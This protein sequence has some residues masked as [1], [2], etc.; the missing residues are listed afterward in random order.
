MQIVKSVLTGAVVLF[1]P[2]AAAFPADGPGDPAG[3]PEAVS[4]IYVA[5]F[6][7][8]AA[9]GVAMNDAGDVVGTSYP[10]PGCGP[11][12]LPPLQTVVWKRGRRIL[13]LAPP[14]LT[15]VSVR[16]ISSRGWVAGFAGFPPTVATHAV[17]WKWN[18]SSYIGTDLGVLPGTTTSEATGID[19]LGR[20]VGWSTTLSFPPNGSPFM[21]SEAAGMVDLSAQGFPGD[22]PLAI[23][24]GGAVATPGYW[25]QLDDP[26]SA[27]PMPSAP[28]GFFGPGAYPT[29][30]ND[31]GDQ[32]RFLLSTGG[33]SPAYLFR[34]HQ[35]GTWQ[36]ISF[37]P[38]FGSS[39]F[40]VGSIN[41][42]QD[43]TA[44]VLGNA[45]IAG[46]PDGL[47]QPLAP[48]LSPAYNSLGIASG[49]PMNASGQILAQVFIG[50]SRRLMRLT[51]GSFCT[52]NCI[53][54]NDL[55][56]IGE[57]VQDPA[58]PGH[59]SQGNH[60]F[61]RVRTTLTV[62]DEGGEPLPGVVVRG[63]FL[64][65]YWTD[66]PVSATT[67]PQGQVTFKMRG[68]CGVGAVAFLVDSATRG[69]Q[70]LDKTTGILSSWVIPQ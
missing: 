47:A 29:A 61:N 42:A 8:T 43:I 10:D 28:Q 58:D 36:Q 62:T 31:S 34:F 6:V 50:R 15:G 5:E 67:D 17:V 2:A 16:G 37:T 49:G 45:Q 63:R 56:M 44:T 38:N 33:Q 13:L 4:A 3:T 54:A 55:Q 51:P 19:S 14:G 25:Y 52:A 24:P 12:C 41:A 9:F 22:M 39:P 30:I 35:Q 46:G 68:S 11:F 65:D 57:F 7:S 23:S 48:L 66:R 20:V 59:C 32:A 60:A 18:G 53:R 64:D 26:S 21:W 27:L 1:L 69:S 40:G 70:T